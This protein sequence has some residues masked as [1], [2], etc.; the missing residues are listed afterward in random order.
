MAVPSYDYQRLKKSTIFSNQGVFNTLIPYV[1]ILE[2]PGL[3]RVEG[4]FISLRSV[5]KRYASLV[6]PFVSVIFKLT[7]T[8]LY[9]VLSPDKLKSHT[10]NI[11]RIAVAIIMRIIRLAIVMVFITK[12]FK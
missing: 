2:A 4:P 6:V 12:H 7:S 1:T 8:V 3:T 5:S 9:G 10:Q 11:N